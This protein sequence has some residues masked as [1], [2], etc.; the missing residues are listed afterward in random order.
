MDN[1]TYIKLS[2]AYTS[3]G[4]IAMYLKKAYGEPIIVYEN[5]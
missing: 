3:A 5:D 2:D 1:Y 4:G